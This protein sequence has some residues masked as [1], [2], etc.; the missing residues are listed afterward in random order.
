MT[1]SNV[2]VA[3]VA[4]SVAGSGVNVRLLDFPLTGECAE[5][6][7]LAPP[8]DAGSS[9]NGCGALDL[10][11]CSA[12]L[13]GITVACGGPEDLPCIAAGLA[14]IG[15][16]SACICSL[17]GYDCG[18]F[19]ENS[20]PEVEFGSCSELGFSV[21]EA[22]LHINQTGFDVVVHVQSA[23]ETLDKF[24]LLDTPEADSCSELSAIDLSKLPVEFTF[25]AGS[26]VDAGFPLFASFGFIPSV[27]NASDGMTG[28]CSALNLVKCSASLVGITVACGGP[29][30]LPCIAAGLA[31]I[32]GCSACV[33]SLIGYNCGGFPVL[34]FNESSGA[35]T[36]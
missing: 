32:G 10:V 3:F 5:P 33:C 26:C 24:H 16:C 28:G 30:D 18:E 14:V 7:L 9:E 21:S 8:Q 15:G 2:V 23:N 29:E 25:A 36:V 11:K 27:Q 13:V 34:V 35:L 20:L 4:N 1:F 6:I 19:Q 17:I 22:S 31:V 12:S